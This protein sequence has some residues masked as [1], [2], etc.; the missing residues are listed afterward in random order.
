MPKILPRHTL[1]ERHA[2]GNP[3]IARSENY[4]RITIFI[5]LGLFWHFETVTNIRTW[6]KSHRYWRML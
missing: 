1:V 6:I 2:Q 5:N 4:E 3:K